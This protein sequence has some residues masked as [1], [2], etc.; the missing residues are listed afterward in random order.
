MARLLICALKAA[1]ARV[2]VIGR[3]AERLRLATA[4]GADDVIDLSHEP[5]AVAAV[6]RR[7]AGHRG[8]DGVIEAVGKPETWSL[9]AAMV[10]KGGRV[11]LFGGCAAGA[12][13]ELETHRIHYNEIAL[14]GV[15]HHR[16]SYV[17]QAIELLGNGAVPTEL[18]IGGRISLEDLVSFFAENRDTNALKAAVIM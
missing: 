7:T 6:R 10:R 4:A 15:F 2:L 11:C 18:L 8:A 9:S 14:F 16:P 13:V 12:K 5:D 3:N 17:R 1:G